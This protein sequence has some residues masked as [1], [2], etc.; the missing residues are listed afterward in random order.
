[1]DASFKSEAAD[2]NF[3]EYLKDFNDQISQVTRF[4]FP[5]PLRVFVILKNETVISSGSCRTG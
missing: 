4:R 5:W 2:T 3:F 1:M